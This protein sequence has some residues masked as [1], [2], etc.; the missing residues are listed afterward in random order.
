M[1]IGSC[2]HPTVSSIT[3]LTQVIRRWHPIWDLISRKFGPR[4]QLNFMVYMVLRRQLLGFFCRH[5]IFKFFF[6][7]G[8]TMWHLHWMICFVLNQGYNIRDI[9]TLQPFLY[10]K[11]RNHLGLTF[12]YDFFLYRK[13]NQG[14]LSSMIINLPR[15]GSNAG[16]ALRKKSIP[17]IKSKSFKGTHSKL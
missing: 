4:W 12:L 13:N 14:W 1:K 10:L 16:L 5:H 15:Y 2:L 17:K 3:S 6:I 11:R 8:Y 9:P 7:M